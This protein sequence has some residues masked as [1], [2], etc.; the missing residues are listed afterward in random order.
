MFTCELCLSFEACSFHAIT[1]YM[2]KV[3]NI[4]KALILLYRFNGERL[5]N[6]KS[7]KDK[8]DNKAEDKD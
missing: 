2:W 8:N 5:R 7:T 1:Q 6:R 4:N 3:W